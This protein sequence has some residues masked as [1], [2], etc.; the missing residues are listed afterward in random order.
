[1]RLM[2]HLNGQIKARQADIILKPLGSMDAALGQEYAK[3]ECAGLALAAGF[4]DGH[5][6]AL[7]AAIEEQ[8]EEL[9]KENARSKS[10]SSA[11]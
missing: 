3:G 6:E 11:G 5:L 4:V 10:D 8:L 7:T 2:A 9:E 1:M